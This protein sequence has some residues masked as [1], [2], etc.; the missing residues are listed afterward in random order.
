MT[1]RRE[2]PE[3]L[4]KKGERRLEA[5]RRTC[6]SV[7][8][9]RGEYALNRRQVRRILVVC[10]GNI[11]RSAVA[12]RCLQRLLAGEDIEIVSG[13]F[14]PVVGRQSPA[15]FRDQAKKMGV[16]LNRVPY[17]SAICSSPTPGLAASRRSADATTRWIVTNGGTA[18]GEATTS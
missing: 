9:P 6:Q 17:R 5:R 18:R 14:H 3:T 15:H 12:Q 16:D 4:P 2:K 11:C 1:V 10:Y 8:E 7:E 13:G